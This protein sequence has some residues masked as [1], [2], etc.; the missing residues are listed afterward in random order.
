MVFKDVHEPIINREDFEAVQALLGNTKRRPPKAENGEKNLFSDI[1]YCADCGSKLWYHTNT[2]N[3]DIHYFSYSNYVKDYRGTCETRHYIR[4]DAIE[5][6]VILELA[7]LARYLD[8]DEVAFVELLTKKSEKDA[9][10]EQ[11]MLQEELQR[12]IARNEAV[13]RLFEK[14]YEDN[15]NGKVTDE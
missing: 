11:K 13:A 4:A 12:S 7:R 3:K 14:L 5:Q 2:I 6:V 15:A 10:A 8:E 9:L 1:L